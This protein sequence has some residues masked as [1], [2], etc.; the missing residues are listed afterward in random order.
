MAALV[1]QK[2]RNRLIT[3]GFRVFF[4]SKKQDSLGNFSRILRFLTKKHLHFCDRTYHPFSC[5]QVFY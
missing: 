5:A 4:L 3:I 2:T 1:Y